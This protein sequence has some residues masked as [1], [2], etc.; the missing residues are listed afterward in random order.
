MVREAAEAPPSKQWCAFSERPVKGLE[1]SLGQFC[2]GLGPGPEGGLE[3]PVPLFFQLL[4]SKTYYLNY[5]P[6]DD[7]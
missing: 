5:R 3:K 6:G 2:Q 4:D 1:G 7:R